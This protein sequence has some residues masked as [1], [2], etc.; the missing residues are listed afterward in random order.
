VY[1]LLL[2]W[3]YLRTRYLAM[4]CIVSVMLGV[5]TLI[6][7]NAVMAGFSTKLRERLHGLLSDIVIE[8]YDYDG[9]FD[10]NGKMAMIRQDPILKDRIE[11]MTPTLEIFA[12]M[13]FNFAGHPT[14]KPI[15]LIGIDPEGRN[16]VGGFA[17]YLTRKENKVNPTF[18]LTPEAIRRY[19]WQINRQVPRMFIGPRDM[20]GAEQAEPV[21]QQP[22]TDWRPDFIRDLDKSRRPDRPAPLPPV[23][24]HR[25]SG[26]II[27][28]AM[29]HFRRPSPEPGLP[30]EDVTT[31]NEGDVVTIMTM[32]SQWR[33]VDAHFAVSDYFQSGLSEY[34]SSY[35][36]LPIEE[37]QRMR[38]LPDRATSI[39]IRLKNY[40]DARLV[41]DRLKKMFTGYPVSV[42]TWEEKQGVILSAIKIERGIL[43]VLLFMI[44]GVA[45]FG[46]LAI[47]SMIVVE[48]TRDIGILKALGASNW[49]VLNIFLGYGLLLGLVGS[50]LGT[51]GGLVFT[52]YINEIEHWLSSVCGIEVFSPG[53]Y[54]FKSIPTDVQP[55]TVFLINLGS[56]GIAVIFSVLP[57]LRAALLH[58]VQALRGE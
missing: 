27:G 18:D 33:P 45:G 55:M 19:E 23:V 20:G 14:T 39:Q 13:Q 49:G 46:I 15:K 9:F 44:V 58:P 17:E 42:E 12:M 8:A 54:Y 50:L 51:V 38:N 11:A 57:A 3:R 24:E 52:N 48:K 56:V 35:A 41:T 5:G 43:N 53:V 22:G 21:W 1:K 6:V 28:Y 36:F 2:C 4:V 37:L 40:D 10:P 26:I 16:L 34:D 32:N 47:F 25:P 31:L 30:G 7:V 29:G